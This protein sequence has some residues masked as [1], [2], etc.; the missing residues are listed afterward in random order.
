MKNR[1]TIINNK[2]T[3][4]KKLFTLL[5]ALMGAVSMN[6]QN[7]D[8]W[9][10]AGSSVILGSSW[11]NEDT[12]NDMT[13]TDGVNYTL[14]KEGVVLEKG[15]NY[16]YKVLKD[17]KWDECY[18]SS[19]AILT[20]NE[21]ATYT[22]TFTFNAD[23]KSLNAEA[24]KTGQGQVAE[25]T[26]SVIGTLEGNWDVDTD[27]TKGADGLYTA[28]F[29]GVAAGTYKFK[30]RVNH[31]WDESYPSSDFTLEFNQGPAIV[32][33]TFNADTKEVNADVTLA[34]GIKNVNANGNGNV[35]FRLDGQKAAAGHKGIV[36]SQGRKVV[37]TGR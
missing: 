34:V 7:Y 28:V 32:T 27:M 11:G 26:Y 14:V 19:N 25:K 10:I 23:T 22:V 16:E 31:A 29:T 15:V 5:V 6:A 12:N 35:Y 8:V 20:V 4:M 1:T 17:H 33:I 36:V 9:T 13:T 3:L 24:V 2:K 18:P 37:S 21:T 30:V